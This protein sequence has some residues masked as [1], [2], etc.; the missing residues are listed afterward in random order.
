MCAGDYKR[1]AKDFLKGGTMKRLN[2]I[3]FRSIFSA[4]VVLGALTLPRAV[5][6]QSWHATVGAQ[7]EDLRRQ[8]MAFLPNEMWIHAGD[9]ITWDFA[10]DEIHTVTFLKPGQIR[11][12]FPLGCPGISTD[13]ASFDG[14]TCVNMGPVVKPKSFTVNFPTPGNFKLVCLVHVNMAAT[15]HVLKLSEPLPHDQRFYDEQAEEQAEALLSLTD[16]DEEEQDRHSHH[17]HRPENQVSAGTGAISATPGGLEHLVVM[18]FVRDKVVIHVGETVE[19]TNPDPTAVHTITFGPEPADPVPPSA[20]VTVDVDG[21][22]H[23]VINSTAGSV[24]SGFL[25]AA[26]EERVGLAQSPLTVTRFR[27]TFTKAGTYPYIC[28]V[29]DQLGMKGEVIVLP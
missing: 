4:G 16:S 29:H 21:A 15:V 22:R 6:A 25:R 18:R 26:P 28:A 5:Q 20:N 24:N 17:R 11:P 2:S 8:A 1:L 9:S 19:W 14:S 7:S 10:A 3:L 27:V 13:P 23:A 12:P